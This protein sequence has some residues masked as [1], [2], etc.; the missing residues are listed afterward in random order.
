MTCAP[1]TEAPQSLLAATDRVHCWA[2]QALDASD[3]VRLDAIWWLSTHLA[4]TAKVVHPVARRALPNGRLLVARRCVLMREMVDVLWAL[5]RRLTGDSRST[6]RS[7]EELLARLRA[8]LP[9]SVAAERKL[10]GELELV[11]SPTEMGELH[12]RYTAAVQHG[13]TR[14]HPLL[15]AGGRLHA[16]TFRL[17]GGIDHLRDAMDNRHI[18]IQRGRRPLQPTLWSQYLLGT[19]EPGLA[20]PVPVPR[21]S[22]PADGHDFSG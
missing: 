12:R 10:V 20:S 5:D 14:P 6:R 2:E 8:L 21:A 17:E 9:S 19:A 1:A 13:P 4:A 11:L 15:P 18:P 16:W 3:R 22:L 7:P